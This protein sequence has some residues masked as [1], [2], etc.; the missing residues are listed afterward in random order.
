VLPCA[1]AGRLYWTFFPLWFF[2][3]SFAAGRADHAREELVKA[4][5]RSSPGR[6]ERRLVHAS[7]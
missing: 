1:E 2:E 5:T 7:S 6:R 3:R 4:V